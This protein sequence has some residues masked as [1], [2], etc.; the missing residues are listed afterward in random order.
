[1]IRGILAGATAPRR[2]QNR[3]IR[4]PTSPSGIRS[5]KRKPKGS[6]ARLAKRLS[7][8]D[9]DETPYFARASS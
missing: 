8:A 4:S 6:S 1:M 3:T 5:R 7:D 2:R 9:Y